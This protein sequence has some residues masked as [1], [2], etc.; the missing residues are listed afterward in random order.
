MIIN[1][2]QKLLET[3]KEVTKSIIIKHIKKKERVIYEIQE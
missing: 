2:N 3:A 1:K